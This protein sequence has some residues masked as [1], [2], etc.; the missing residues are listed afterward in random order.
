MIHV[1]PPPLRR[2]INV[3][4]GHGEAGGGAEGFRGPVGDLSWRG[5]SGK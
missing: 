2:K 1:T 4:T 5:D 3:A